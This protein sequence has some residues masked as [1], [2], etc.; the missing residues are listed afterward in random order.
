[1]HGTQTFRVRSVVR[2]LL[3]AIAACAVTMGILL[4]ATEA[5]GRYAVW[6][7][8]GVLLVGL[9]I[10]AWL[11]TRARLVITPETITYHGIGYRVRARWGDIVG[12]GRR[13][14]GVQ[15]VES[16]ILRGSGLEMSGWMALVYRLMPAVMVTSALSGRPLPGNLQGLEDAIPVG[17][18]DRDWRTGEIGGLVR[19]YAPEAFDTPV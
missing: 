10:G 11:T 9:G 17:M 19:G 2:L 7:V 15:D 16:L 13:V 8:G 6:I 4:V 12:H 1:M 14:M 5:E 18:F 3:P